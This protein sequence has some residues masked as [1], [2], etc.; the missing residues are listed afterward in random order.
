MVALTWIGIGIC[1]VHSA[2]FSG[3]N[4]ALLGLTRLRLEVEA[5][6]GNH[7]AVNILALRKDTH[8]L[9]TTILWGNVAFNILLALL[10]NSMLAGVQAFIFSTFFITAFGEILPQAYFSKHALRMGS[11]LVPVIRF[12]QIVLF[13]VAKPTALLLDHWL[14][15]EGIRYFRE[16]QFQEVIRRHIEAEEADI[17]RLEGLGALN[18]LALDDLTVGHEGEDL[19]PDSIITLSCHRGLPIFPN[20]NRS[21]SDPFLMAVQKSGHKWVTI[22]DPEDQPKVVLDAD[23]FLRAAL[24]D[25]RECKPM[26]Y[27]HRPILVKSESI[28]LGEVLPRLWVQPQT[29]ED[30]VIDNDIILVWAERRRIITGA[31]ILGRLL[32]GIVVRKR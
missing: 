27:C 15:R 3:L 30:D 21:Q 2:I 24:F 28:V 4:L 19:D 5:G 29:P 13:P 12:Y 20:F 10:S 1:L 25:E 11:I 6:S 17:D 7:H 14:G 18:F 22:V 8:F 31:D 23:G 16:H 26:R 9:L 32:R